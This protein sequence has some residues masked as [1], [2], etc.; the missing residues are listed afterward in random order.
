MLRPGT[1]RAPGFLRNSP[2]SVLADDR[3]G[4]PEANVFWA[5]NLV[6]R[7]TPC[8]AINLPGCPPRS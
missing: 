1:L 8:K 7:G 2:I 4:A 3:P 6:K 5:S